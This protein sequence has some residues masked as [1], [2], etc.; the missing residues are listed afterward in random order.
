[1]LLQTEV[2][3]N[4]LGRALKREKN[5]DL[6]V[7]RLA[8]LEC[9]ECML[10]FE[11]WANQPSFWPYEE[12]KQHMQIAQQSI[13]RMLQMIKDTFPRRTG[14]GWKIPKFHEMLHLIYDI[15]RYGSPANFNAAAPEH[16]H[17]WL[18]KRPGRHSVKDINTFNSQVGRRIADTMTIQMVDNLLNATNEETPNNCNGTDNDEVNEDGY[19][20]ENT[21]GSSMYLSLIHI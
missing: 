16:N 3:W 17:I 8:I 13:Q 1:M 21:R 10:C 4:L 11:Q 6:N 9:L 18:A 20:V 5:K 12:R 19:I 7:D 15:E 2:G 14:N